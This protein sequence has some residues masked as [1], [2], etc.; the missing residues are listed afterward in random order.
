M[1]QPPPPVPAPAYPYPEPVP[2][3]RLMRTPTY[4]TWRPVLGVVLLLVLVF[5]VA[6]FVVGYLVLWPASAIQAA[7]EGVPAPSLS[8][9]AD[10]DRLT[11]ATMLWLN[12]TLGSGTLVAW[13]LARWLHHLRPRWL[14]S[15]LPGMRWRFLL[16]CL[17]ISVA[18]LFLQLL[19]SSLVPS[20][21]GDQSSG[22]G[23]VNHLGG[24][25]LAFALVILIT[26]PLQ[27]TAEEYVFRGYLLQAVGS[28]FRRWTWLAQTVTIV[29][30]ALTFAAAHG[31]QNFPLFFDRFAFGVV[32][33]YLVIRVGGLE[34]GFALH[35]VNNFFAYSVALLFAN[36]TTVLATTQASYWQVP[37]TIV[38]SLFYLGA[39]TWLARRTGVSPRTGPRPGGSAATPPANARA[40]IGDGPA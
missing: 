1:S 23:S 36:I 30:P 18:A 22:A 21:G 27:S 3:P 16:G 7:I 9:A 11:P 40:P 35:L 39:V 26:T 20:T 2:Y 19:L 38:Q 33:G 4:A 8:E 37:V 24:Q 14:T 25:A 28:F 6:S 29:V 12:L 34:A 13:A 17:P 15:V 31:A 32:A 10:T 5:G